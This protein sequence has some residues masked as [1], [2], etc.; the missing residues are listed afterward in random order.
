MIQSHDKDALTLVLGGVRSGKSRFAEHRA[1][2]YGGDRVMYVATAHIGDDEMRRR[3]VRHQNDRPAAW[4]TVEKT[5]GIAAAVE[6]AAKRTQPKAV[7]LDCLTLLA[8]NVLI[9]AA[10]F[11]D[12]DSGLD[13]IWK[14]LADEVDN[15]VTVCQA[16][17]IPLIIVSGEVG[18]GLVPD[19]KL[20]RA[21]RDLLGWE[22]Q[23]IAARATATYLLVAGM[24]INATLLAEKTEAER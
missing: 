3:I 10:H 14:Q 12:D 18:M 5:R 20:G 21:F 1:R 7:L 4:T 6:S 19:N 15:L 17:S 23:R 13:T 9:N 8:T 16:S 22:N 11:L 24:P 2:Q